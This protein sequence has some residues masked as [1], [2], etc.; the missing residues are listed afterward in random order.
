MENKT[1]QL[2]QYI[3]KT[4]N[5]KILKSLITL[6]EKQEGDEIAE[7]FQAVLDSLPISKQ[8][9]ILNIINLNQ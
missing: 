3:S 7:I 8:K 9:T 6:S 2:K 4:R 1:S 5:D